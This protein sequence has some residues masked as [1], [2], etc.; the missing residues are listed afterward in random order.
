[1][2]PLSGHVRWEAARPFEAY[3][4][5]RLCPRRCGVDRMAAVHS[6]KTGFCGE[7]DQLRVAYVGPH[8]GEEPPLS[9]RK[10]SGAV[11]FSGCTLRCTF[12]QNHQISRGGRGKRVRL[13]HLWD[14]VKEMIRVH[15]VHNLNLVTPDHFLPHALTLVARHRAEGLDV[16]VVFNLSGYQSPEWLDMAGSGADIYLPD[17]KYGDARLAAR[18][19]SCGEYPETALDAISE[20]VR[21][22]GFL[23]TFSSG[24]EIAK[25]GV[26]VRHLILP[27]YVQNSMDALSSL[28]LEFGKELP[29]SLM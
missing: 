7:T 12:C 23:D 3:R 18:L 19:S 29:L 28:F 8:F 15:Q 1:M 25:K 16:P 11:F 17:F 9:G 6:G 10:G 24:A 21:Q 4:A 5:C 27:G 2:K 14:R 22:K 20:M 26:L 13:E